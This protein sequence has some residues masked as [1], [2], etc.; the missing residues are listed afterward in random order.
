MENFILILSYLL[1]GH[2]LADYPLQG[3]F[4]SQAKNNNTPLG[5]LFWPHALTAHSFIQGGFV[6]LFTDSLCL[7]ATEIVIHAG[8]DA[9]KCNNKI[10]LNF[11]QAI[12]ILCKVV[13]AGI[14]VIYFK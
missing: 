2:F 12:H 8:T 6:L 10:T 4:L 7:M 13:W 3:E 5:K 11:D 14:T 9:L 1:F